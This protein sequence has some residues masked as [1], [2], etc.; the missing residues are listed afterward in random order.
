MYPL[1]S[2]IDTLM[3]NIQ[4]AV[5]YL[6][7]YSVHLFMYNDFNY[8]H[9]VMYFD[10]LKV[11][12]NMHFMARLSLIMVIKW[13][14]KW[15]PVAISCHT[16]ILSCVQLQLSAQVEQNTDKEGDKLVRGLCALLL[17]TCIAYHDG[18]SASYTKY[19]NIYV[20]TNLNC[21]AI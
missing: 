9:G 13:T 12:V 1:N 19:G 20:I 15:L 4:C 10:G 5:V 18:S 11:K 7:T 21:W 6:P 14:S 8:I 17:G 2:C 3:L 16:V